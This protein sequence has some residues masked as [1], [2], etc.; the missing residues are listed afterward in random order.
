VDTRNFTAQ[1]QGDLVETHGNNAEVPV[2][3]VPRPLPPKWDW[4]GDLWPLLIEARTRLASLDGVGKHLAN[5]EILLHPLQDREA[6]LSS[7]LEGTV[8][9]PH[10]QA[11]FQADPLYPLSDSDPNNAYREVFNYK[12]ALRYRVASDGGETLPLSLRLIKDLHAILLDGVRGSNQ[13]PGEFR[14]IQNQIGRPPRFVPPPP[15]FLNQ[16]LSDFEKYLHGGGFVDPLVKAF[17]AHYQ[18]EAIHPFADGN[19]R[20][21]RL[22]LSLCIAEWCRLS[23]QWL[24]MSPYFEKKKDLYMDLMFAVSAR[25][26]WEDWIRFCLQGVIEQSIDTEKRCDN[27]LILHRDFHS[28]LRGGSVRLSGLVDQLFQSP[29]V[30]VTRY[31]HMFGVTYPTARSDLKKLEGLGIVQPLETTSWICYYC[32]PI[33]EITYE[34]TEGGN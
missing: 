10:Q 25:G 4:P 32:R 29:V 19:G 26:N 8:T 11:L 13:R 14:T 28:R 17:M 5:P 27:L 3:F 33:Y 1:M 21:G 34:G 2:A 23:G 22:L 16:S 20:V 18:F 7:K 30:S 9:D 12:Q 24:Y 31:T 15:Q 6:Q